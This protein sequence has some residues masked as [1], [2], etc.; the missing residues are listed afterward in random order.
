M[1]SFSTLVDPFNQTTLNGS[2]W[3]QTTAGSATMAYNSTGAT[4]TFPAASTATTNGNIITSASYSLTNAAVYAHILNVASTS[5]AADCIFQV[6][7]AGFTNKL[8]IIVEAGTIYFQKL[9]ASVNTTVFS[10]TY[11]STTHAWWRIR[12]TSGTTFWETAPDSSGSPGSW[13]VQASQATP[14]TVT[15]LTLSIGGSCYQVEV[16]PGTFK[17]NNLN[18]GAIAAASI[19]TA[20]MMGV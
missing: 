13:T 1:A 15:A 10:T 14:I 20:L 19:S 9:V 3:T 2:L 8:V 18:T 7:D 5:T 12:E 4:M 6:N 11:S 17:W 16:S